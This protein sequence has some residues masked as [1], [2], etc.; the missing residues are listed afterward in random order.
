M[1]HPVDRVEDARQPARGQHAFGIGRAPVGIDDPPPRQRAQMRHQFAVHLEM[2]HVDVVNHG[3]IGSRVHVMF[4]HQPGQRRAVGLPVML[5]QAVGLGPVHAERIHDVLR[6][7]HFDLVE[8][9]RARRIQRVVEVEDPLRDMRED[10]A[11]HG[12]RPRARAQ[13]FQRQA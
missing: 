9:P 5:A 6:H 4:A 3:Q 13:G 12:P 2:G 7:A 8:K 1:L 11:H 10:G